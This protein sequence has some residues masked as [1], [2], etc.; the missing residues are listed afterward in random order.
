[1]TSKAAAGVVLWFTGLPS[2]GKTTLA[3]QLRDRLAAAGQASVLLDGDAV[4]DCLVPRPGYSDAE[5]DAFYAT[6]GR[7]AAMLAQQ[8]H[9]VLVPA[10]ANKRR[11]RDEARAQAPTFV[12]VFLDVPIEEAMRRDQGKGL[13]AKVGAGGT[14]P[15]VSAAY[16]PPESPEVVAQGGGDERALGELMA[17][18]RGRDR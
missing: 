18:V 12:E 4:R 13:Y 2:S 14:L 16:E 11:Y 9:V 3:C 6:L 1:M 17:R 8:G 10:T 15:G 5:R 7:L